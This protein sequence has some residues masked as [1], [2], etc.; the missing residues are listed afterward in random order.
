[1]NMDPNMVNGKWTCTDR[2]LVRSTDSSIVTFSN[3]NSQTH[4]YTCVLAGTVRICALTVMA[5]PPRAG[6]F[7]KG[8]SALYSPC[9]FSVCL[10][11][12]LLLQLTPLLHPR[13][14]AGDGQNQE[15]PTEANKSISKNTKSYKREKPTIRGCGY[16]EDI[17]ELLKLNQ[18]TLKP[19]P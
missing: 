10:F 8:T 13:P 18:N 4:E 9:A 5:S 14:C 16:R 1:M 12:L 17:Q 15:G 19:K 11:C 3:S 6:S 7:F 2:A